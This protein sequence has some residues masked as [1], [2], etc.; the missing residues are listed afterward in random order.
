MRSRVS[1]PPTTS[2]DQCSMLINRAV[3]EVVGLPQLRLALS[4]KAHVQV[5][6]ENVKWRTHEVKWKKGGGIEWDEKIIL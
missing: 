4:A 5:D 3:L 6:A 1:R 2:D